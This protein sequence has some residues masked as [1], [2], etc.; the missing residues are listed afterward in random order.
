MAIRNGEEKNLSPCHY[1]VIL[2]GNGV[3]CCETGE[4]IVL[5]DFWD[6]LFLASSRNRRSFYSLD[7]SH[8]FVP[9]FSRG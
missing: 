6:S 8:F 4:T 7:C 3:N 2:S 1:R 5:R 9:L